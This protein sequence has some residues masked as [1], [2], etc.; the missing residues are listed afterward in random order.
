MKINTTGE[1]VY[2]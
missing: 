2:E 1:A